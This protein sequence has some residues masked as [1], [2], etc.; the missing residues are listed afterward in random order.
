[1]E[2]IA[3]AVAPVFVLGAARLGAMLS[4]G[5]PHQYKAVN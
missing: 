4:R 2:L 1:M 3:A 5:K